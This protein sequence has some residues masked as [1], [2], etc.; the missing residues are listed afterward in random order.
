[1]DFISYPFINILMFLF[2]GIHEIECLFW[3]TIYKAQE[4][5]QWIINTFMEKRT[6]QLIIQRLMFSDIYTYVFCFNLNE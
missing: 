3:I 5:N 6:L 1:M 4:M 2:F